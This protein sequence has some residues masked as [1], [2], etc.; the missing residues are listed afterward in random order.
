M[1]RLVTIQPDVWN[2][3]GAKRSRHPR[4]H[5]GPDHV[6]VIGVKFHITALYV[7]DPPVLPAI[8]LVDPL[9]IPDAHVTV[10]K[11]GSADEVHPIENYAA[12]EVQ[13]KNVFVYQ[14]L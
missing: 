8:P 1:S 3:M 2:V 14:S 6:N 9:I 5:I 12:T 13:V 4:L 10:E 11:Q 7:D